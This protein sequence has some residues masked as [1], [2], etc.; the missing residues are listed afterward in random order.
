MARAAAINDP[1]ANFDAES[2]DELALV[3]GLLFQN[4]FE[5]FLKVLNI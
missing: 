4:C 1:T 5:L 2:P 3:K